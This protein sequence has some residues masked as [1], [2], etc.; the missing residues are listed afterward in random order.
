MRLE[1]AIKVAPYL[2][3]EPAFIGLSI[4]KRI[5]AD[6]IFIVKTGIKNDTVVESK[7]TLPKSDVDSLLVYKGTTR[8]VSIFVP[9]ELIVNKNV[10]LA[11]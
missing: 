1:T 7:S 3:F 6:A 11:K 8:N 2:N 4:E 5:T 9:N 10:F